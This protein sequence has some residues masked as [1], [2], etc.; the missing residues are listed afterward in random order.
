M[1]QRAL[2]RGPVGSLPEEATLCRPRIDAL[3]SH[4]L[5][6]MP[7]AMFPAAEVLTEFPAPWGS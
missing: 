2:D 6:E 4:R 1:E 3:Q 5:A 7:P